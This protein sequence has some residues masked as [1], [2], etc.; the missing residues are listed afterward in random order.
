MLF[1]TIVFS[2]MVYLSEGKRIEILIMRGYGD[3]QRSYKE[4]LNLF[5][6]VNP[7]HHITKSAVVKTVRRYLRTH[8]VVNEPK[9]GRPKSA[10]NDNVKLDVL[11]SL[12]EN[13]QTSTTQLAL[14]C[15]ISQTSVMN[16]MKSEKL[17]PY[18][19]HF[20]H[21][22]TEDDPDRR[23]EFCEN[24]QNR[25]IA[26]PNFIKKI[27]FSDEATFCLS[28][29]VNR[30]NYRIWSRN[31]PR[32]MRQVHTQYPQKINVWTGM[33]D[34]NIIGP[35][36]IEGNLTGHR[37]LDLL[38]N[39]IVPAIARLYP[40]PNNPLI[41]AEDIWFQQ[42]GAPAHYYRIVRQYLDQVF[43]GRWIGRRGAIEWPPRSPDLT[44]LDFFLWGYLKN[45]VYRSRP[46]NLN[47]LELRIRN[48][49]L[50]VPNEFLQN[51]LREFEDR[52]GYCQI[53]EGRNFEHL[54]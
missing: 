16:I 17:K 18:K 1:V 23:T 53:A 11:L 50:Q 2:I 22:L 26:N 44:P 31:N 4:V 20:C 15:D 48:L 37:Y 27:V 42:D 54:L 30:H 46:T 34:D 8:H 36:F 14:D 29:K 28:G 7:G 49:L 38:T 32:W 21:E 19:F 43:P 40:H 51:S 52:L 9:S 39:N 33:I 35:F 3:K 6:E 13:S 25:C 10:T 41:P 12:E 45:K 47:D 5:N 24:I